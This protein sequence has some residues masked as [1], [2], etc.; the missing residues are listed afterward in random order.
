VG[1][2]LVFTCALSAALVVPRKVE[3]DVIP[4]PVIDRAEQRER[5]DLEH[6]RVE[7]A[8][9]GLPLEVRSVGEAFRRVGQAGFGGTGAAD[10]F[11]SQLR[12]LAELARERHGDEKLLELRAVQAELFARAL[13]EGSGGEPAP[14][15]RELGG[16]FFKLGAARGWFAMGPSAASSDEVRSLFQ[17][18]WGETLGW[19]RRQPY[20]PT[21]NEW[22]VYFRFLLARPPPDGPDR[23]GDLQQK[24]GYVAALAQYD[25]D[26]PAHLARGVILYQ[27][28]A[29]P[30]SAVELGQHL[31][32][33]PDGRWALRARN[34]LAACGAALSE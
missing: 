11:R 5:R 22:R 34:Y 1:V 15:L 14:A 4:L 32:Q 2:W 24:L 8:Q 29:Y 12:R 33:Q 26:Y 19:S 23:A 30:E 16:S 3:P 21:L 31:S 25:Q 13:L 7:H 27:I 17:I 28:G 20:A 18:Y 9:A 6:G 10:Q